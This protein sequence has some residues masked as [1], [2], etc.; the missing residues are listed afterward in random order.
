[1]K[2]TRW[3]RVAAITAVFSLSFG[4]WNPPPN[5]A[6]DEPNH[7]AVDTPKFRVD[8]FW[9]KPLP[10]RWVAEQVEG[11][12]VDAQDHVFIANSNYLN[13]KEQKIAAVPPPIIEFDPDGN[14]V[15]AWGNRELMPADGPHG[16]FVDYQGNVWIAGSHDAIVQKY[17]H[18]G[19]KMLLQIGTKGKFDSSDGTTKGA[20]L[21]SSHVFLNGPTSIAVDPS[22]GDVYITDGWPYGNRRVVVFDRNGHFLRQWGRQGT[23]AE[24]EAGVG[25]VFLTLV[26]CVVIGNDGMVYVCDQGGFRIEVFD[27]MGNFQRNIPVESKAGR[28]TADGSAGWIAFSPDPAQK[29]IYVVDWCDEEV[30]ILNHATGQTV[31]T[32]GRPGHQAG[33][34]TDVHSLSVDSKGNII[35]GE[36]LRGRRT[37]MFRLV[38]N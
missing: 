7:Q 16:C 15:N 29:F 22:N 4:V 8:P 24:V 12:C 35:V 6:K 14:V 38:G 1:M 20:P 36:A 21:N 10:D 13:E 28:P 34:F 17:S 5:A 11:V 26:H 19:S 2:S 31:S 33:E 18:D 30:R 3:A 9:P 32:F 23:L 37:Q 25:G 27:K